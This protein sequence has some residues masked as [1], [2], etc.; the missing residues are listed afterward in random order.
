MKRQNPGESSLQRVIR[1]LEV[2][3]EGESSMSPAEIS[4][5]TGLPPAS[6]YRLV[7]EMLEHGFLD[8]SENG[9][10]TGV[11]LWELA[12]RESWTTKLRAT[13]LPYLGQLRGALAHHTHLSI[14]EGTDVLYVERLSAREGVANVTDVATRLPAALASPGLL[15]AAF[16]NRR[17]QERILGKELKQFS[18]LTPKSVNEIAIRLPSVRS[19]GFAIVEGWID[20]TVAGVAA[21]IRSPQGE[22]LA[23]VSVLVPNDGK[24][25]MAS[26]AH[27]KATANRIS[28]ALKRQ[29][30]MLPIQ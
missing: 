29:A 12:T 19:Q 9:V 15:F 4:R 11:K 16:S 7:N 5:R 20:E 2:F 27:V 28:N 30:S 25:A 13:S 3:S 22:V 8:R 17:D 10:K 24:S 26:L 14:L 6:T 23:A 1:I 21:P 18:P